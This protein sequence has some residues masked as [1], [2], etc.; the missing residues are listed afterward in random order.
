MQAWLLQGKTCQANAVSSFTAFSPIGDTMGNMPGRHVS[1]G[2][3][4][5]S[6]LIIEEHIRTKGPQE[7]PFCQP[8]QKQTFVQTNIPVA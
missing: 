2:G 4:A 7:I 8:A 6:L 5:V 3:F 1:G